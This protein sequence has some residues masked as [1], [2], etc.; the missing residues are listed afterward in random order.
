MKENKKKLSIQEILE[1]EKTLIFD[2]FSNEDAYKLGTILYEMAKKDNLPVTIDITRSFQQLYHVAM[3]GTS[4][5]ND[6]W[7]KGKTKVVMRFG[8]SSGLVGKSLAESG[9]TMEEKYLIPSSEFRAHGGSFPITIRNTG[10][11]GTV[12]VSGLA[13]DEDHMLAIKGLKKFLS[14]KSKN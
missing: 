13:S 5:D 8:H 3:P 6:E 7:I 10:V 1:Q 11:I 12:T 4:A 2:S 9:N 14:K